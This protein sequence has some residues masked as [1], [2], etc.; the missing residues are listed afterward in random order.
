MRCGSL[1][2]EMRMRLHL[3]ALLA[4]MAAALL[5]AFPLPAESG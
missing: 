5:L 1:L 4:V 3:Y 2:R